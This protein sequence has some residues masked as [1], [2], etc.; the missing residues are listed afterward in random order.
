MNWFRA[1]RFLGT[2]LLMAGI[3]VIAALAFLFMARSNWNDAATRFDTDVA[4]LGRLQRLNPFPSEDNLRKMKVHAEDYAAAVAKLKEDLKTRVLPAVQIAPSEFQTRLRV[5]TAGVV[6][7]AH[8]NKVKLPEVFFLGFDEYASA[9]PDNAAA[10]ALAQELSQIELLAGILVDARVDAVTALRRNAAATAA[11][12][13]TAPKPKPADARGPKT[14]ERSVV[15][16]S[17]VST[18]AA[19]RRVLNQIATAEKQFYIV[20]LLHVRNEKDKGPAREAGQVDDA[21][22]QQPAAKPANAAAVN[23]IVGNEKIETAMRVEIVRF[24]F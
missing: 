23:F 17:F 14:I 6:E 10:P 2:F 16:L 20:R 19:A 24:A 13:T 9:L 11:Q 12:N 22:P 8:A 7:R 18:P 15:D 3:A 4:E 1:N 21:A 5:A